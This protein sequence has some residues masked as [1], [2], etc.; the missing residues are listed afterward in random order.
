MCNVSANSVPT[1]LDYMENDQ[2][3]PLIVGGDLA[4]A[5]EFRGK[6]CAFSFVYKLIRL[7]IILDFHSIH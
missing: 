4:V 5:G 3:A 6:V 2:I 1:R 7:K